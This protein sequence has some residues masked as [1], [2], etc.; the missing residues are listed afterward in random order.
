MTD[1][2]LQT[3]SIHLQ[4]MERTLDI[5]TPSVDAVHSWLDPKT[6]E[7]VDFVDLPKTKHNYT[8]D[9]LA[10]KIVMRRGSAP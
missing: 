6:F 8:I 3:V 10:G 4:E 7:S 2:S 9:R 1:R 5:Q